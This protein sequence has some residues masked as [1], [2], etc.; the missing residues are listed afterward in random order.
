MTIIE[1][2]SYLNSLGI[3][4]WL[5]GDQLNY[6]AP[7]GV[8]NSDLKNK[9]LGRKSEI[10]AFLEEAKS[11]TDSSFEPIPSIQRSGELPLS[12]AQ[13]RMWFV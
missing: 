3:K 4:I 1:F 2:V 10:L 12:F 8:M 9:L 11:A 5:E 7:K 6:R 13:Q